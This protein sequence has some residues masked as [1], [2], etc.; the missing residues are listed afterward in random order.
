MSK[1]LVL[2]NQSLA[3]ALNRPATVL[4]EDTY[5]EAIS[6]IIER[7]F[8]PNLAKLRAQQEYFNAEDSGD[9]VRMQLAGRELKRLATTP[10]INRP[11]KYRK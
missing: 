6:Y 9:L 3:I 1:D 10:K 5:T 11:G 7:D 4:D 8:F 2:Q